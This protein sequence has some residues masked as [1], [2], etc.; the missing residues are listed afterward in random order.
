MSWYPDGSAMNVPRVK[1]PSCAAC[2]ARLKRIEEEALIPLIISIDPHDPRAAGIAERVWRSMNPDAAHDPRDARA[3]EAKRKRVMA[4]VFVPESD[5]GAFPGL[6][7]EGRLPIALKLRASALEEIGEK[8]T[9]VVL[10]ARYAAY[11]TSDRIVKTH[12]VTRGPD[13]ERIAVLI[14]DGERVEVPPGVFVAIRRAQDDP[15]TL[16]AVVDLWGHVRIFTSV[17]PAST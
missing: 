4:G 16:M 13:E 7:R 10:Y 5:V 6:G 2:N 15:A 14:R 11:V 17:M 9:R 8:I 1:A 3:R 12:I